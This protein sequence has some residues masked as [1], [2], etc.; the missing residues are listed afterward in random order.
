MFGA[1]LGAD[2]AELAVDFFDDILG[3]ERSGEARPAGA[4]LVLV[5]RAEQGL[6]GDDVHVNAGGMVVPISVLEWRLGAVFL[7]HLELLGGQLFAELGLAGLHE[8][9]LGGLGRCRRGQRDGQDRG[10]GEV[11]E[12]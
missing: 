10:R 12:A 5:E 11:G 3:L 9:L 7:G 6:T 2:H 4:G 1:D 8:Y